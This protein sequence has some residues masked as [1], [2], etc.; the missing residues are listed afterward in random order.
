MQQEARRLE[1]AGHDVVA[2]PPMAVFAS[3]V[4]AMIQP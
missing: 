4:S 2:Y 3:S 1:P